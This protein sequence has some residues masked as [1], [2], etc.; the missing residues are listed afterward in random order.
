MK[1]RTLLILIILL[2]L[3]TLHIPDIV[4]PSEGRFAASAQ[5]MVLSGD[6]VTPM[7]H[8]YGEGWKPYLAKP[9]FQMW[10]VAV[11]YLLFGMNSF[12]ARLPSFLALI[13]SACLIFKYSQRWFS[14]N[15]A[16]IS[17]FIFLSS[18]GMFLFGTACLTDAELMASVTAVIVGFAFAIDDEARTPSRLAG[19]GMFLALGIGMLIKGPVAVVL[20]CGPLFF[21]LCFSSSWKKLR[22]LP[23]LAGILIFLIVSVPWY[24][25]ADQRNP[26]F[27][28]YFFI[29]ENIGRYLY[30]DFGIRFGTAHHEP[31]GTIWLFFIV[32]FIPWIFLLICGVLRKDTRSTLLRDIKEN[33][34]LKIVVLW[35]TVPLIFF[36]AARQILP[37]YT[38][39]AIPAY[40]LLLGYLIDKSEGLQSIIGRFRIT[41]P[42]ASLTLCILYSLILV[43]ADPWFSPQ[44]STG[45]IMRRV[46]ENHSLKGAPIIAL[47]NDPRSLQF[48]FNAQPLPGSRLYA[49]RDEKFVAQ[50]RKAHILIKTKDIKRLPDG[51]VDNFKLVAT[52]GAWSYYVKGQR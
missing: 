10:S 40:A 14:E 46:R 30:K 33:P 37:T 38:F 19:L 36:T 17:V 4:D 8:D 52:A 48:Y 1:V 47:F 31:F 42:K 41:V 49:G 29:Q 20:A 13:L 32:V 25:I 18:V 34:F 16:W 12:A 15:S 5:H 23:W 6:W 2:R 22:Y 43:V 11:S 35:A 39:A 26:H 45:E 50:F 27:L 24:F 21:W 51:I 44:R 9:P 7:I 28:Y 3:L